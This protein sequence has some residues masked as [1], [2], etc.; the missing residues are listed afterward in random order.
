MSER[1][2]VDAI[3]ARRSNVGQP[4]EG[5]ARMLSDACRLIRACT[6]D[7]GDWTA[8]RSAVSAAV[9]VLM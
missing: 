4:R 8:N 7:T 5:R 3:V 9:T 2:D 1:R 6:R